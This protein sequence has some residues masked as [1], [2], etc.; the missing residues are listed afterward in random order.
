MLLKACEEM[1]NI[2]SLKKNGQFQA[3]YAGR[4]SYA[5]RYLMMYVLPNGQE[6]TRIGISVS[7]RVGNSIV[8][9]RITRLIRESYRLN[10][11]RLKQGL[12]IVVVARPLAKEQGF[13]E[14]ESAFLHL[15]RMHRIFFKESK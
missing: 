13:S 7:K 8:R 3:V 5:N 6:E 15:G 9:H 12:D 2:N 1:R 10:K 14:I 4:C 11:A